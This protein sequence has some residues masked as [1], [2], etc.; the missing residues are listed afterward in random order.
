VIDGKSDAIT[1]VTGFHTA[2]VELRGRKIMVG[3]TSVTVGKGLVYVGSR[4]DSSICVI[5]AK[6]LRVGACVRIAT[7]AEGI[8]A[9]PDG[10]V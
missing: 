5:D 8:A 10:V 3:P 4:A 7:P 2:E 1:K 6:T 9:A